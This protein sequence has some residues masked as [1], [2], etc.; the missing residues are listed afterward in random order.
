MNRECIDALS[1]A[2]SL[3]GTFSGF[4]A[5]D[6]R[7][8]A[9]EINEL[10]RA[11]YIE[12]SSGGKGRGKWYITPEGEEEARKHIKPSIPVENQWADREQ[13]VSPF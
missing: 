9:N 2:Y 11:G 1:Y 8:K 10:K 13:F 12:R 6:I 7:S 4:T 3:F 5:R